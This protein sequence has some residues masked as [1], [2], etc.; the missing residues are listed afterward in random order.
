MLFLCSSVFKSWVHWLA[1]VDT[2]GLVWNDECCHVLSEEMWLN[3]S[4]GEGWEIWLMECTVCSRLNE[5]TDRLFV[6]FISLLLGVFLTFW[7]TDSSWCHEQCLFFILKHTNSYKYCTTVCV[8][9][10][11][12][13]WRPV[14]RLIISFTITPNHALKRKFSCQQFSYRVIWNLLSKGFTAVFVE[15]IWSNWD[16]C[17]V[18]KCHFQCF[19]HHKWNPVHIHLKL[20]VKC[21]WD[22]SSQCNEY[23]VYIDSY[24][25]VMCTI[26]TKLVL[27]FVILQLS[28][29]KA[30]H[31]DLRSF[32]VVVYTR[33][34][35][36]IL[37]CQHSLWGFRQFEFSAFWNFYI[38]TPKTKNVFW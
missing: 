3:G 23:I 5:H 35:L 14:H 21:C 30:V 17:W 27:S 29:K 2:F 36:Y 32:F 38:I 1:T 9:D 18:F 12:R 26:M 25:H 11:R 8:D 31:C 33:K 37:S 22:M 6:L 10:W 28:I 7:L 24:T 20:N 4:F 34:R 15:I 13:W 19:E 16:C